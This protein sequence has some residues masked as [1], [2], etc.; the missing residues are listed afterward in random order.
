MR[1]LDSVAA[2][3]QHAEILGFDSLWVLDRLLWPA[4][5]QAPYPIG[6]GSLPEH[7]KRV[8]DPLETLTFAGALTRKIALG[9]SVL[10]LP[11]YNPVLLARRLTSLDVL[12]GGRLRVGFGMGWS[13][14][15][16]CG[17]GFTLAGAWQACG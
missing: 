16:G 5:P 6:G 9:T 2:V 10:N 12:S 17:G 1:D 14:R 3:A 11:W 15:R 13:P 4:Q 7:Y 8:L